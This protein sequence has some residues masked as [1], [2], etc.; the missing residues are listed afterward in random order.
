MTLISLSIF[1]LSAAVLALEVVLV[2][3]L[4]IGHWH[5]F[6]YMVIST[7]LLGFG[8]GGVFVCIFSNALTKHY[9]RWLWGLA[10]AFGLS[11]PI[12]FSRSQEAPF[13]ELQ[14]IW[15]P[16]QMVFLLEHYI[17]FFVPFLCAGSFLALVFKVF[18]QKAHRLYFLNMA[19]SGVGSA[20]I[21][22]LM[23]GHDPA[24]LL[25]VISSVGF[26]VALLLALQVSRWTVFYTLAIAFVCVYGIGVLGLPDLEINISEHKSLAYYSSLPEAK[27]VAVRYSPLGRLDCVMAP[28]IR[29]FP[30][31][32]IGY[33]GQLPEQ[34]LIIS[35]GDG[36]SAVNRF[37]KLSEL[38]CYDYVTS[39][40]G[41]HLV[42]GPDVCI[43]GAGGGSDVGQA[44]ILGARKVTAVEI[45]PQVIDLVRNEVGEFS[46][47]LYEGDD[48]D[49]VVADGRNFLQRKTEKFDVISISLLDSLSASAAGL[50]ALNESHLYTTGAV[51]G[52]L[53]QLRPGGVLSI[54]RSLKRPARDS[55]KILATVAE[56]LRFDSVSEPSRYIM[57]IRSWATATVVASGEPFSA[58]QIEAARRFAEERGFDL[59]HVPGIEAEEANRFH[60]LEEPIYYESAQRILSDGYEEFYRDYA[61]NIRPATDDRPYFFDF[62]KWRSLPVMIRT[63]GRQWLPFSEWGYLVLVVTLLQAVLASGVFIL[64]PLFIAK[65][66]RGIGSGKAA[67]FGYFL[68]LGFAYMFLEMGFIQKMTLLIGHPVFGVAV[69]LTGFLVFSGLGSLAAGVF[70]K[71]PGGVKGLVPIAVVAIVVIGIAE[72]AF[73]VFAFEWLVGFSQLWRIVIGLAITGPL[74][75]F[76]GVPFPTGLRA[77]GAGREPLVPWAWGVNGFASVTGAVLGTFLAISMGFTIL[78]GIALV[79]YLIAAAIS[80]RI[81]QSV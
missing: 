33:E 31:L 18:S 52:A 69:T 48:V 79:C 1:L 38:G 68:L 76:M 71:R 67:T 75:F 36:V 29:S 12:V 57:M 7:A 53:R 9:K 3:A 34:L 70:F 45:N 35:D 51:F 25:I 17:S 77:I 49:V 42:A 74:A 10:F 58:E 6:A 30:G 65:P 16:M 4:A 32:S 46:S 2:R 80:R 62:F 66:L 19:G 11:V 78:A 28:S 21:V 72:T 41:Y 23:Y 54:T 55:L 26:L 27:I 8:A 15:D 20:V 73:M 56:A 64:L 14:L 60:I 44:F 59:V 40:I 43:I 63:L 81:T 5:H 47:G 13:D 39:A 22:L 24:K 50:Y 37:E 61:Y